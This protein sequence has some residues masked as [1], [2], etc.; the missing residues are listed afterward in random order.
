MKTHTR[1]WKQTES[2]M[3]ENEIKKA[4]V[5]AVADLERFPA[6]LFAKLRKK[7]HPKAKIRATKTRVAL[8]AF[9]KAGLDT[10]KL[11]E[12]SGKSIAVIF[13][14]MNAFE[15]FSFVR[16]GRGKAYAKPGMVL[17]FDLIVPAGDTG[18]PPGPDLAD[19]KAAGIPAQMSGS[20]IKVPKDFVITKSGTPVTP[21]ASK[22]L[23][24]LDIK[25]V[26]IGL[27]IMLAYEDNQWYEGSVLDI[28]PEKE[29]LKYIT[30]YR[31]AVNLAFN[32]AY[33]TKA[34]IELLVQ[35][36][37]RDMKSVSMEG[38]ITNKATMGET[39]ENA[40]KQAEEPQAPVKEEKP[41]EQ[42]Q[43]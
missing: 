38:K 32:I 28:D 34:T 30:A 8:K 16:K 13:S 1:K 2:Q 7:L 27:K 10:K 12:K 11:L 29:T 4:K 25:P 43:A 6:D 18:L 5:I 42:P 37:Y 31:N 24:K 21:Q 19:L 9:E 23:I 15:L 3:L 20:S 35:K 22:A 33:P 36:A 14:E 40:V 17:P 26:E 41:A 39:P